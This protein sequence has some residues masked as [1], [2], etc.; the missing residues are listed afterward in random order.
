[1]LFRSRIPEGVTNVKP[2]PKPGWTVSTVM[3]KLST[4][5]TLDHGRTVTETVREVDWSGGKLRDD[6]YDEFV[7]R[8]ELPDKP[9]TTI[10]FPVVQECEKGINRW[11]EIP[12][13]GAAS[14][15]SREPAPQLK[16]V[17]RNR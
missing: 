17:P 4:P 5:L 11:I 2:Q 3:E 13:T 7:F 9:G 15:E 10:Y 12:E 1:M 6:F 8:A 14:G 16:L